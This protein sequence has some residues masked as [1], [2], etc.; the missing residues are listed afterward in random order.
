MGMGCR[1]VCL[2]THGVMV[3]RLMSYVYI[4]PA[5]TEDED[6]DSKDDY[7]ERLIMYENPF[8]KEMAVP[9]PELQ[10]RK[11]RE[12]ER[13]L[14]FEG[15]DAMQSQDGLACGIKDY[16]QAVGSLLDIYN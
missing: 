10:P 2:L 7:Y 14:L 6:Q 3:C 16:H 9:F 1:D 12:K 15:C 8:N 5:T 4:P 11:P 13:D